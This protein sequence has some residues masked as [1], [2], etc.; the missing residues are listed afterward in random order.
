MKIHVV[1]LAILIF[2]FCGGGEDS[3]SPQAQIHEHQGGEPEFAEHQQEEHQEIHLSA[4]KQ[5]E[6]G[7]ILDSPVRETIGSRI[8][9]P[10]VINLNQNRTAHISSFVPGKVLS[11]SADLGDRVDKG[12]V[13]LTVNSPEFAQAKANFLQARAK[14]NLSRKEYERAKMLLKEKAIEEKEYLRREAEYEKLCTEY[15][16]YGSLLHSYGIP[17]DRIDEFLKNCDQAAK[18]GKLCEMA[19]P[20]QSTASPVQGTIIF[21]DAIVGEHI[22]PTKI[23][24]IVSDLSKLWAI[25]DAYE[26]DLPFITIKSKVIIVSSLYPEKN[27]RG[28]I[29]Y[30]SDVIDEK[31]RTIKIRVE[32]NN[33]EGLLKPNMFIQGVIENSV[34]QEKVLSIPEQAIQNMNGKKVVFVLEKEDIFKVREVKFGA[35]IGNRRVITEGLIEGD[36]IVIKGAF[37]LKAELSKATFGHIHVH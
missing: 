31:L 37:N 17:H 27:F 26:K 5:K 16:V 11:L 1:L 20:N 10:G 3:V 36:K 4:E 15:G 25:L 7:I 24:F 32:V 29:A 30:I 13:L 8:V 12:Q 28:E 19:N 33:R 23:L 22:E 14:L 2:A 18:E 6:W 34:Q 35:K 9:L 21:R